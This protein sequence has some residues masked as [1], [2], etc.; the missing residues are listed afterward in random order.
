MTI[1]RPVTTFHTHM[2]VALVFH[3]EIW[4]EG[5]KK[6]DRVGQR[7]RNVVQK[8]FNIKHLLLNS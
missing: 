5:G 1:W 6:E 2:Q 8:K 4:E 7:D 3:C